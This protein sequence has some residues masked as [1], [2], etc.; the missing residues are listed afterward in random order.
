[1]AEQT[2]NLHL[3]KPALTDSADITAS[4]NANM[5]TLDGE[6]SCRVKTVNNIQPDE[7]G[8]VAIST[9]DYAENLT[10]GDKVSVTES[11]IVRATGGT[12]KVIDGK[13]NLVSIKAN[14]V[15]T[16]EIKEVLTVQVEAEEGSDLA[17]SVTNH[18]TFTE[19]VTE[20]SDLTFVYNSGWKLN[21]TSVN[22]STTYGITVTGT[23][24]ANDEI[25]VHYI[26]RERGTIVQSTPASQES[27]VR[28]VSTGWNLYDSTNMRARVAR[29]SETYGYRIDGAY[30]TLRLV[31]NIGDPEGVTIVPDA[32]RLFNVPYAGYLEV[33][34]GNSAT[35]CIYPTRSDWVSGHPGAFEAY[36]ES[37]IDLSSALRLLNGVFYKAGNLCDEINLSTGK[38]ISRVLRADYSE[39]TETALIE[40]GTEYEADENYI[41]YDRGTPSESTISIPSQFDVDSHGTEFLDWTTVAAT[42]T[43]RYDQDLK[44]KLKQDVV[45]IS[46]GNYTDVQK[47]NIRDDIGAA[48][49]VALEAVEAVQRSTFLMKNYSY[50]FSMSANTQTDVTKAN[51]GIT[52]IEGYTI[53]GVTVVSTG[54][55]A[56]YAYAVNPDS[57]TAFLRVYNNSSSASNN[58]TAK[59]TILWVRN[60]CI[61][62]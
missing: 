56:R 49:Q 1:M 9:V 61:G 52:A 45:T 24:A 59:V 7:D 33:T 15:H 20:D 37:A 22:L 58:K 31:R 35:T 43:G 11:F 55:Q 17:A 23:P 27:S 8:D 3:I 12:S 54:A 40:A 26:K 50:K 19:T 36:S 29:Y 48:G 18:S 16:G 14:S 53:G 60:D 42:V 21:G 30:S 41:Y 32:N 47:Q 28:F 2:T 39:A 44:D 13:A 57:D 34:G 10:P 46:H 5:D 25:R 4:F 6:V 51:L 38:V 62:G